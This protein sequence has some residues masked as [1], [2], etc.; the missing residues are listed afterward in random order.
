MG[1]KFSSFGFLFLEF[2]YFVFFLERP[3]E[4]CLYKMLSYKQTTARRTTVE[5]SN[6]TLKL[7]CLGCHVFYCIKTMDDI[8]IVL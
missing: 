8:A 2:L 3:E 5:I 6:N 4:I 1:R 7:V